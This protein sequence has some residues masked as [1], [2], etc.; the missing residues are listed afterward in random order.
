MR[1]TKLTTA[2]K[3][4]KQRAFFVALAAV[5]PAQ[6]AQCKVINNESHGATRESDDLFTAS[7]DLGFG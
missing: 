3:D 4:V 5:D 6:L 2:P 1:A 7:L